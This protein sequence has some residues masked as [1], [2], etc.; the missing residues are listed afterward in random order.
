MK[1]PDIKKGGSAA[2]KIA[3]EF[4]AFAVKGNV[5]DLAVGVIIGAAFSKIVASIVADVATPILGMFIGGVN[6]QNLTVKLPQI[7]GHGNPPILNIGNFINTVFEFLVL[8]IVVFIFVKAINKLKRKQAEA[9]ATPATPTKEE[10]LLIEIRD[11]L[12]AQKDK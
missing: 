9:P 5:I 11:I 6:F 10:L 2:K 1:K 7:F 4:K 3:G 8:A 12:K